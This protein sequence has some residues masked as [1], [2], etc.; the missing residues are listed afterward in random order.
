MIYEISSSLQAELSQVGGFFVGWEKEGKYYLNENDFL[1]YIKAGLDIPFYLEETYQSTI[2]DEA[3]SIP[4]YKIHRYVPDDKD[5]RNI[6][7]TSE[8]FQ[9]FEK[10]TDIIKG[11][12]QKVTYYAT[13]SI[14]GNGIVTYLDPIVQETFTWLRDSMGFCYRSQSLIEWYYEDETIG[15][16]TKTTGRFLSFVEKI[17]E[18]KTRRHRIIN[19]LQVPMLQFMIMTMPMLPEDQV[20]D[21]TTWETNRRTRLIITG[22]NFLATHKS[23]FNN[24]GDDSNKQILTDIANAPETWLDNDISA[25][26]GVQ[27]LTMRLYVLDQ[28]NVGSD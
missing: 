23:A 1:H 22:R 27:G 16:D 13:A 26:T 3:V 2:K 24:F 14:D 11:E 12:I 4:S 6:D 18:G 8:P 20:G 10:K 28:L 21:E 25:L 5:V 9:F 7:F 17:E 15:P 19:G